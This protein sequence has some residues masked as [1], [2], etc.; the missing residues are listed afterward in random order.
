MFW[1]NGG[2]PSVAPPF[3]S[4]RY[5]V[6]VLFDPAGHE[7]LTDQ[8][9]SES[10]ARAAIAAI[11]ADA[12]DA[13]D[14]DALWPA[15]PSDE[16]E[17]TLPAVT[18][19]YLG[20]SG[21]IWALD[22]LERTGAADL[23]RSWAA[24]AAGLHERYLA[25]PDFGEYTGG[26][27]PSLWMGEAG[28]L[29]VA[30]R[31]APAGWQEERLLA[32]VLANASNPSWELMWGSPGTMLAAGVMH[33]RTGAEHW[34]QAWRESADRLWQEWRDPLW[35]QDLYGR[36]VH[37]LGPAHGF[38]GNVLALARGCLLG[39]ARRAEL[40][41]RTVAAVL[42][43]AQRDRDLAQW[44]AALE[45][46]ARAPGAVR[47]QWCH[48]APGIVA[49]LAPIAP[50]EA[51]FTDV[52]VAGGE[53]T[54]RAGPLAK[55]PGLCHGTAGNG[56]AFLKLFARTRDEVWLERARAFA[57]HAA[58]QVERMHS[59]HGRGR[60]TLWTGDP[61]TALFLS[62]CLTATAAVPTLDGC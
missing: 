2:A 35:Q 15:H 14:A 23:R 28:I 42:E 21:V 47:T 18:S 39:D 38:A 7:R 56:Y 30:H 36:A 33:E 44:P 10:R 54:W 60:Y 13:F 59:V 62:S 17:G 19:L 61:G 53:L 16:E 55:G 57:M 32:C 50:R 27:V 22:E 46:P 6:R 8:P 48:G 34:A 51:S 49:S 4:T 37:C 41:T 26:A 31:L 20:A 5:N 11:V 52:L 25:A 43:Y 40:E 3:H 29:L 9:W 12:Q 45:P 1:A 24:T 58:E